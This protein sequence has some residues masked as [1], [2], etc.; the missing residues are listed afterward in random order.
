M[1]RGRPKR[2]TNLKTE[3]GTGI[4]AVTETEMIPEWI[5]DDPQ[6]R[7]LTGFSKPLIHERERFNGVL[8][9]IGLANMYRTPN[10]VWVTK[11]KMWARELLAVD[12][13]GA[14]L[15]ALEREQVLLQRLQELNSQCQILEQPLDEPK[16]V[17]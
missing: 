16:S 3:T 4:E 2:V 12:P 6:M 17:V 13:L 10:P 7:V 1:P 14:L 11:V 5:P 9:E 15:D 8:Q